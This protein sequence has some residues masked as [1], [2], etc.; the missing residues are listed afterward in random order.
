M[1]L[2]RLQPGDVDLQGL[3][4]VVLKQH[5]RYSPA[6]VRHPGDHPWP[7]CVVSDQQALGQLV[8]GQDFLVA[9]LGFGRF[10]RP[11]H[12]FKRGIDGRQILVGHLGIL[13][14]NHLAGISFSLAYRLAEPA[15]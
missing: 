11:F 15:A 6:T 3:F 7:E 2:L 4:A 12:R 10:A 9:G 14:N 13:G 8:D 1:D 5:L